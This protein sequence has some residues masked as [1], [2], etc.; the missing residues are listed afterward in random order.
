MRD[1]L[2]ALTLDQEQYVI[3]VASAALAFERVVSTELELRLGIG[4]VIAR[5]FLESQF[6]FINAVSSVASSHIDY[7]VDRTQLFL[8]LELLTVGD[9]GFWQQLY[10]EQYQ[11]SRQLQLPAYARP[12][13]GRLH[14]GLKYS[15]RLRRTLD[16]PTGHFRH[17]RSRR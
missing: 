2:R 17:L 12:A 9:D 10:E 5:D 15:H 1:D 4:S 6:A 8:D 16:V 14:P 13:Y 3:D 11:P 7:I